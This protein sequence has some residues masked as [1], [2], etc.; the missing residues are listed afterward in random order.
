MADTN[1]DEV[2]KYRPSTERPPEWPEGVFAISMKGAA[3]VGIH[4]KTGKLYSDGEVSAPALLANGR[5]TSR[6]AMA[7][8]KLGSRNACR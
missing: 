4:E 6:P 2:R 5:H 3:L 7:P 1:W 8:F